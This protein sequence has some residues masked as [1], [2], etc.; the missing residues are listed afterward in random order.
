MRS[1]LEYDLTMGRTVLSVPSDLQ[2]I[3]VSPSF[4]GCTIHCVADSSAPLKDFTFDVSGIVLS[5]EE[6]TF[7]GFTD[8][9]GD[10]I[11]VYKWR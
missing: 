11:F 3:T 8:Q 4:I 2:V 6:H 7:L 1:N 5:D 9:S 10:N